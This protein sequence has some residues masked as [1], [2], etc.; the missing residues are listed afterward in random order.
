MSYFG[1]IVFNLETL[2]S[3]PTYK[4]FIHNLTLSLDLIRKKNGHVL[5][6]ANGGSSAIASHF[7]VDLTKNFHIKALFPS[8]HGI[9]TCFSND[10]GYENAGLEYI[11]RYKTESTIV[12]LIS[13][14]GKSSNILN[15]A[16]YCKTHRIECYG[17]AGFGKES[18]LSTLIE[19][20]L[21]LQIDSDNYNV[22]EL[23]HLAVLL[24]AIERLREILK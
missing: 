15:A 24:D 2:S 20:D 8:D 6:L 9:L 14:S 5:I 4:N 3:S 12:L 13:S 23:T 17:L 10:Y 19:T 18:I 21:M 11:K 1:D 7:S 22:I 16:K